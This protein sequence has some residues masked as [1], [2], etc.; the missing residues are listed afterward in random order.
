MAEGD[1]PKAFKW[2]VRQLTSPEYART[3]LIGAGYESETIQMIRNEDIDP[4]LDSRFD[5]RLVFQD[6]TRDEL[7][8]IVQLAISKVVLELE[9]K[10]F[11]EALTTIIR[12]QRA[13]LHPSYARAVETFLESAKTKQESRLA[14]IESL[15]NEEAFERKS[16]RLTLEDVQEASRCNLD[17][18]WAMFDQ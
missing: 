18:F 3:V 9:P 6:Y 13:M 5:N 15:L 12:R 17:A 11:N 14:D 1:R 4:K 7:G 16:S 10:V 2:M 8:Q